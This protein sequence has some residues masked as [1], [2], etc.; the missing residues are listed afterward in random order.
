M[1]SSGSGWP[2]GTAGLGIDWT[3]WT[4]GEGSHARFLQAIDA[5]L[6]QLAA[7]FPL[8][9]SFDAVGGAAASAEHYQVWGANARNW[10]LPDG[11]TI[12][13]SGQAAAMGVQKPG[14][15]G[16]V[17]T[18]KYPLGDELNAGARRTKKCSVQ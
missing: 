13:G 7:D 8:R 15:F 12:S 16:I 14:V 3:D 10:Q 1:I 6:A 11:A 9:V 5:D 18:P 17:T 2:R 4:L